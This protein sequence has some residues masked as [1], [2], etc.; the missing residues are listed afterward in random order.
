M[1]TRLFQWLKTFD[2]HPVDDPQTDY[3]KGVKEQ[4]AEEPPELTNADLELLFNQLLQGVNQGRGQQWAIRYLQRMEDRISVERWIDWLLVF[5]EKLLMSPAPNHHLGRQM[6]TLGELGIGK[7]GELSYDIGIRLLDR[8]FIEINEVNEEIEVSSTTVSQTSDHLP[9]SPGQELIRNLGDLLWDSTEPETATHQTQS[10]IDH[11]DE[12]TITS[13]QEL[14]WE[15]H[16]VPT[17]SVDEDTIKNLQELSWEYHI[18]P[19]ELVDDHIIENP[20]ELS[21]QEPI[22]PTDVVDATTNLQELTW[23]YQQAEFTA[24]PLLMPAQEDVISNLSELVLDYR[25]QNSAAIVSTQSN[26]DQ[27]LVN[28]DPNVAYTLDELMVRLDQST[29]LVQQLAANLIVQNNQPPAIINEHSNAFVKAQELFYQGLQLAKTG[30]LSGAIANYE[31]AIQLNPNSYEYWFNRGLTLFHL[32]RFVEAIASY[33]QAIEIKPDYYKAWYNRGGT[34]GQ[35]GLYEEAVASLKQA[36]TIQPDMPGAW[37]SKG[38]AELKLGQIGEAIASYDEALL[39]SPED[40]EN[41]YYRGIALGVDEQYEAAID[42]YDKALEIQPDFHEVWIDRGVVLFNLKQWSEAIASWDQA[43]S[44]Q[45]DFYLAWYNRGVALENLGHREE[46]I[47]SYKQAI[48]IKPDFHLAWYNQAVALFYLERFLEAIVC[49]DNALQIK[50]DYWEAWIGRGTAIGNLNETE[51]P[52]NLLT[53]IAANNSTLKQAGYEGK[54]ASYQEGLKHIRPDTHPEGW[55]RLHLAI[56]NTYYEQGKKYSTSRNYWRKAVTEYNQA[57]LTLTSAG[58]PQLHLEVLQSLVKALLGLGQTTQAQ[59]FQQRGSRLLQQLLNEPTRTAEIKKQLALKFAGFGQLAVDVAVEYGDLVE[60]WEIAEQGKNACLTWL[61]C[62]WNADIQPLNYRAVQQLLNPHTAIIYWHISP[63]A[64]HT[65]IVKDQAPSPILVFTPVQDLGAINATPLQ[66]LP[67]PEAMRRLIAF[68][69]WLEDWQQNYQDYHQQAQDQ[70][71][72]SNHPWRLEMEHKLLQ[73]KEIL[74]ID[75]IQQEL[76]DITQLI[77][78]PHRDLF[79][80]PLHSLF[81]MSESS[82]AI[83]NADI[84]YLPNIQIALSAKNANISQFV[85]QTLLSVE[86]PDS[87]AYPTL[88]FA[89]LEAEVV[90]QMFN[91]RQRLQGGEATKNNFEDAFFSNYN[92]LH[93]TG[94]AI[95]RLTDPQRSEL[96]LAGEDK[97]T[98]AE[99]CETNL[100]TYNLVTLSTCE[101]ATNTNQVTTSEYVDLVSAFFY[102]G[103]SQVV[104]TLWTVESSASALVIIEFYRRLQLVQSASTALA[105]ATTWLRE[106]TASELT[107]WYE[108]LLNNLD[109]DEL[110][111][112]AYLATHLYRIS[113]MPADKNL[114]SH[115]YYW[116]AFTVTGKPNTTR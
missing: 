15:Y 5:G 105:E 7:V 51:T 82:E 72:K 93:F 43:L 50:L 31:Q 114:Y 17:G 1:L 41:W 46:A 61:L 75:T 76:E 63:V 113:K 35:L 70:Q 77:L 22:A 44:I 54:L 23:E 21:W 57:L 91:N 101:T 99:I 85:N 80:V 10:E 59:E 111:L 39:L 89:N 4:V 9:D 29:N 26:W 18:T 52:L 60:A 81:Q 84:A 97:F 6:V 106:L 69:N 2:K 78:V 88:R 73:L 48:A 38:W 74:E 107:Q 68:E 34:L 8:E 95:N 16:A 115:P 86:Y 33:D 98:L 20:P 55:G 45:A 13:L 100:S 28:L 103:V 27:S 66:D 56:A 71:S 24:P 83:P 40:Q 67:L 65:F 47:A 14:S 62:G 104:S 116:A 37:S 30:D 112:R 110:K 102:K 108:N 19:S 36:I 109:P 90:S 96:A 32:E 11:L 58:F 49:Y 92:V 87:T 79:R 64:L 3:F 53:T 25:E 94:Q 42:S 12:D